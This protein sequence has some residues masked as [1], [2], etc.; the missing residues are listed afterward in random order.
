MIR[1]TPYKIERGYTKNL[2]SLPFKN[3]RGKNPAEI[4]KIANSIGR[5][6]FLSHIVIFLWRKIEKDV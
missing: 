6:L 2:I 1:P 5:N 4:M 3:A